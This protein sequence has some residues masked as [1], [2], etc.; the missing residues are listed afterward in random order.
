MEEGDSRDEREYPCLLRVTNGKQAQFSTRINPAD[1]PKF[2][3]IYGSLLKAQMT[4][5]LRKRDKNKQKQKAEEAA[6]RKAKM[7]EPIV[8]EGAKRGAGRRKW[9]RRMKL[10]RQQKESQEKF[11]KREDEKARVGIVG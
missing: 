4:P 1:L 11:R 7:T 2:N 10:V 6:A 8:I 5:H 9:Q 3:A